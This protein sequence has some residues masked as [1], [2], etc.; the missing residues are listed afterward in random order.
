VV[1]ARAQDSF[2]SVGNV[3]VTSV[4]WPDGGPDHVPA[5]SGAADE[6]AEAVVFHSLEVCHRR[7][8]LAVGGSLS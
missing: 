2:V 5:R 3:T 7:R 8:L 1:L 4:P 6:V